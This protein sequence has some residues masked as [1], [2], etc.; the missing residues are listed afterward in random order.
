M[1]DGGPVPHDYG[2]EGLP[3]IS[4][5]ETRYPVVVNGISFR[6]STET[7]PLPPE[8][9]LAN[10]IYGTASPG[11]DLTSLN[12]IAVLSPSGKSH[13]PFTYYYAQFLG[14]AQAPDSTGLFSCAIINHPPPVPSACVGDIRSPELNLMMHIR[15]PR[16]KIAEIQSIYATALKVLLSWKQ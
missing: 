9:Q 10:I 5:A 13:W 14:V 4:D 16:R 12:G 6:A 1:P 2:L 11:M 3:D 8:Q 7:Y 15:F